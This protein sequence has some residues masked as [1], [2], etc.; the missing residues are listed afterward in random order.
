[1]FYFLLKQLLNI[2]IWFC[3]KVLEFYFTYCFTLFTFKF[4]CYIS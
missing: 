2:L 3:K 1:M 4:I